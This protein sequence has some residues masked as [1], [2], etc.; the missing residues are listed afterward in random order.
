MLTLNS[1]EDCD[2][3]PTTVDA[4]VRDVERHV[5]L[6]NDGHARQIDSETSFQQIMVIESSRRI[7]F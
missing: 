2:S 1:I 5:M 3:L 4:A 6:W 7:S